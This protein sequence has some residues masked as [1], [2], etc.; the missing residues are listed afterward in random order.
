MFQKIYVDLIPRA[1][2]N[3]YRTMLIEIVER[4]G[5]IVVLKYFEVQ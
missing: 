3:E 4:E 2:G 5:V 1:V